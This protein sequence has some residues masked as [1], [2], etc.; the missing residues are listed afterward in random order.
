MKGI[1]KSL[2]SFK[3]NSHQMLQS[4]WFDGNFPVLYTGGPYEYLVDN[5]LTESWQDKNRR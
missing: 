3:N 5:S 2:I 4:K 1:S